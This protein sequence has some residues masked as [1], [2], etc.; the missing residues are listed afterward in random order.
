MMDYL[1]ILFTRSLGARYVGHVGLGRSMWMMM[2]K[3]FMNDVLID[4]MRGLNEHP[5]VARK[6]KNI[7]ADKSA[8][9]HAQD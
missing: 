8:I 3:R 1:K 9:D 2:K 4:G 7:P 6:L 5:R